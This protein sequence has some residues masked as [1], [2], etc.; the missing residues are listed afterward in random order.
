M[1]STSNPS[2]S[3]SSN[4]EGQLRVHQQNEVI[5]EEKIG[6]LEYQVKDKSN[7]LKFTQRQLDE[8][9]RQKEDLK[10]KIKKFETSSKSVTKLLDSQISAKVKTGLAYDSPFNEKRVLDIKEEE[11]TETVFDNCSSDEENSLA[12]D[13]FK[14]SRGYHAI[15][16]PLVGN[17]MPLKYNVSF[18]GLDDSIYKFNISET[19]A[20]LIK[21]KKDAPETSTSCVEKPKEDRF[22]AP[23]IQDWDTDSDNDSVFRPEPIPAKIDFVKAGESFKLVKPVESV[24]H[25]KPDHP[26]QALKNEGIVDSGCSRHMTGN[27]A[28]LADYQEINDGRFVVFGSSRASIDES[29]LWHRRLG[30]VNFKTMNKLVTGNLVRGLPSKIFHN[31]HSCVAC[32]KGKQ[33]KATFNTACYVLNRALVTK[34]HNKTPYEVLNGR[35]PRIDLMRP[36][37]CPVTILNTLYPLGKFGG[38][39]DERFLVGY[40]VTSKAFR[41]FNTRNRK[42]EENLHVR[43]LENK[44]NVAGTGSNWLFD[45]DS[46]INYMNYIPVSAE[47]QTDKNTGPQDTTGNAGELTFFLRLQVKQSE[48]GIFI[49]QDKYVAEILKKFDFSSLKIASTPIKTQKPLVKD[50]EAADVDVHLYR[51]MIGSLMYLTGSRLDIMFAVSACSRFQV[52]PKLSYLHAVRRIFRYLKGQPKLGL[53]YPRHSIFD[54]E[55]YSDSDYAGTNLDEKSTTGGCQ[56]LGMRLISWQCKKQTIVAT[57]T[58]EAEDSYVKKLIQVLKIHTDDNVADLLTKAFDV[59][60]NAEFHQIVNFLST[61]SINYALTVSPTIYASY[62]EQ[63]WNTATS[64]TVNSV[65]QIHAIVDGK[66]MVISESSVR[67]DTLFNDKDE[68]FNDTYEIPKH[69]KKVF[70]NMER[71]SISFSGKVTPLFDSM[72]VQNQAPEGEG[73]TIPP[74]PQPA[75]STSQPNISGPQ[76]APLQIETHPTVSYE[77]QTEA[78]I[79]QILPSPSIYQRKHR[80]THKHRRAKKV[81]KLPQTSVPLDL[82]AD[83]DVHKEGLTV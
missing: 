9:L 17:Y 61:C 62:I 22:S 27:K 44:P 2:S 53:W 47:N 55:A 58:T 64:K 74:E 50:E 65:K 71:K 46:L 48:E 32:Q 54:L 52:T 13:K 31:D 14:K 75:P 37:G 77:P 6:V 45:I 7:L 36:F 72:L 21:N 66:A 67:S 1:A 49:S 80:K 70:S 5:Y 35:T 83:E 73:S 24:K 26:H 3:S 19:I 34:T 51:S 38:N 68:P 43:F 30:H 63:F 82:G 59:K 12:N 10:A 40:S 56:F 20:S 57:S 16:P 42:V 4:S 41:V 25:V 33:H 60:E 39:A 76:T 29:N 28:Y 23:L 15:P 78:H 79:E 18:A 8:A 11:V 69:S 81:T